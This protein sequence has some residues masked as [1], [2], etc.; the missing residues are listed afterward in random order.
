M[1]AKKAWPSTNER[2]ICLTKLCEWDVNTQTMLFFDN[3]EGIKER[4]C[5]TTTPS[6]KQNKKVIHKKIQHMH[7]RRMRL[8]A[9]ERPEVCIQEIKTNV[10]MFYKGKH[11]IAL[12][13]RFQQRNKSWETVRIRQHDHRQ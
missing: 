13:R 1:K 9:I 7:R 2:V 12:K 6:R 8:I 5:T 10:C 11:E 3:L 4:M